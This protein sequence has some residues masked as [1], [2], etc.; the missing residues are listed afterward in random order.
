MPVLG[1]GL[2]VLVALFFA[3][4]ALRSGRELY[5]LVILFMFPL[6]GSVVYF[7]VVFLPDARLQRGLRRAGAVIDRAV[8]PGRAVREAR[9]AVELTPT[10]AN[11]VRLARQLLEGGGAAQ[12]AE[13]VALYDACLQGPFAADAEIGLGAARARL[14]HGQTHEAIALLA[15]VRAA[16]PGF[17]PEQVGLVLAEA[18]TQAGRDAE[19][20]DEYQFLVSRFG[21]IEARAGLALWA[22]QNGRRDLVERELAEL[23][24]VRRHMNRHTKSQYQG[25]FQ[26][27]DAAAGK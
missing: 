20:G 2:H 10:A 16:Q 9:A 13:A 23:T 24:L 18:Y 19:A 3:I 15:S 7:A 1:L 21:S 8:Q 26:R 17:R 11:Q 12:I 6:L 25:L 14:A 4:H 22:L 27:L 5:W